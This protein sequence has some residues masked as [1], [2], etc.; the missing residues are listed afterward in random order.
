MIFIKTGLNFLLNFLFLL[1]TVIFFTTCILFLHILTLLREISSPAS[2]STRSAV[3]YDFNARSKDE[4]P[5]TI[6]L[7]HKEWIPLLNKNAEDRR[8]SSPT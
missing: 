3:R 7:E 4:V 8:P 2:R 5:P 6:P 1:F